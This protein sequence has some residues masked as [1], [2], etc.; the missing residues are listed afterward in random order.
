MF[1]HYVAIQLGLSHL[2]QFLKKV[3]CIDEVLSQRLQDAIWS[4]HY[5]QE[6]I[7]AT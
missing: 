3:V 1:M 6:A 4:I 5:R 7:Q 2:Q